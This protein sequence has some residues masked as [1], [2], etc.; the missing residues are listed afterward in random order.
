M[1]IPWSYINLLTFSKAKCERKKSCQTNN[2]ES[3]RI[4]LTE[5]KPVL[6]KDEQEIEM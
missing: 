3:M 6:M 2:I 4:G 1:Q 5:I